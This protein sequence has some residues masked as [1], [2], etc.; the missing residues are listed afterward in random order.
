MR[1]SSGRNQILYKYFLSAV[2]FLFLKRRKATLTCCMQS[3]HICLI[4][5]QLH[6]LFFFLQKALNCQAPGELFTADL[7][8]AQGVQTMTSII[9]ILKYTQA[10]IHL[11]IITEE[12]RANANTVARMR[13]YSAGTSHKRIRRENI[14]FRSLTCHIVTALIHLLRCADL[15]KTEG[16]NFLLWFL[17]A[18]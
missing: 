3:T 7:L 16:G 2:F 14:Y 4:N 15:S 1:I 5:V 18:V 17:D 12:T 11:H 6:T 8:M 10:Y 9:S 13:I